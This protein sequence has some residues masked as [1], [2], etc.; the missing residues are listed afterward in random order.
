MNI[1]DFKN[2]KEFNS[3]YKQL[4]FAVNKAKE[5]GYILEFGVYMAISTNH[6]AKLIQNITV[7]G[8]D[9]FE[10]L[11]EAWTWNEG[12]ILPKGQFALENLPKVVIM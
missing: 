8:Y 1:E 2:V 10:G 5:S 11:P 7:Y 12:R 3:R 9:S 4:T 6:I